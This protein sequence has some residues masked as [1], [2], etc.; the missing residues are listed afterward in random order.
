MKTSKWLEWVAVIRP[1]SKRRI[2]SLRGLWANR[3]ETDLTSQHQ[4]R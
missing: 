2:N 3:W 4:M 1:R